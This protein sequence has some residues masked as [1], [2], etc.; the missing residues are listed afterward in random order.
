MRHQLTFFDTSTW[1]SRGRHSLMVNLCS[2]TGLWL[3]ADSRV[4]A[5]LPGAVPNEVRVYLVTR[6]KT[7]D[8]TK[9]SSDLKLA[10]QEWPSLSADPS[11]DVR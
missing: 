6:R 11:S 2:K 1:E 7:I 10:F 4:P 3:L 8:T 9:L 5:S